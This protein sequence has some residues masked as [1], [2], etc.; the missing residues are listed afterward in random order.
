MSDVIITYESLYEMLRREKF[1]KELQE[2]DPKFFKNVLKYLEEKKSILKSQETKDSVFASKSI[3]TTRRQLENLQKILKDLYE[4][5]ESKILQL[6]LFN[7]RTDTE[8][9]DMGVLLKEEKALYDEI[10][11]C[12]NGFRGDVLLRLLEG[13][14]PD[15]SNKPKVLKSEKETQRKAKMV[16]FLQA[17]PQFVGDDMVTY[18]PFE[19]E[20]VANLPIN[21]CDVLIKRERAE[22]I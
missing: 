11:A 2:L 1:R 5:R 21:V 9:M 18:G 22:E 3:I 7:S 19:A 10:K 20:D 6:A 17:V 8:S 12:L 16:R 14:L 4:R 13:K 15:L